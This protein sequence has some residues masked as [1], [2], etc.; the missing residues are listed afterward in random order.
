MKE[1]LN[2]IVNITD[3]HTLHSARGDV[4]MVCF[5][6][7][8]ESDIFRGNILSGGVD[9]QFF[10]ANHPGTLSAR[11]ML[12]GTDDQGTPT[13]LFIENSAVSGEAHTHPRI[14][15]DNPRLAF[16]EDTPLLGAIEGREGGVRIRIFTT[17]QED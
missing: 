14:L 11:Y 4:N 16:L 1:L 9:T 17:K 15:T 12:T 6:G 7:R 8:C 13:R 2:I 10:L 3:C 5:T